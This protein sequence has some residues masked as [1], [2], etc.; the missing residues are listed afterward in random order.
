M[1]LKQLFGTT[2]LS[3][4]AKLAILASTVILARSLGAEEYGKYVYW[5]SILN[6]LVALSTSGVPSLLNK[7]VPIYKDNNLTEHISGLHFSLNFTLIAIT[8]SIFLCISFGTTEKFNL[9]LFISSLVLIRGNLIINT[10]YA[11]SIKFHNFL[12]TYKHLLPSLLI[13]VIF[14]T[15]ILN[16]KINFE[17]DFEFAIVV[18]LV[19]TLF[20]A[21]LC[22]AHLKSVDVAH[23]HRPLAFDIKAWAPL[24]LSLT[25]IS[26]VATAGNEI[27]SV[28]IAKITSFEQVAI[29][30]IASQG[31]FL[32]M[33]ANT[34]INQYMMPLM[35][36][37]YSQ[38]RLHDAQDELAKG[39]ILSTLCSI[40]ALITI[41]VAGHSIIN[42]LFG[43]AYSKTITPLLILLGFQ[44]AANLM[45]SSIAL[46][47]M[48]GMQRTALKLSTLISVLYIAST[49]VLTYTNG[50]I[51]SAIALGSSFLLHRII[52]SYLVYK[53]INIHTGVTFRR[54]Y[55]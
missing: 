27:S 43:A 51:G 36:L 20:T 52:A 23:K 31:F 13:F 44:V 33:I 9:A 26:F 3:L 12:P 48:V 46:L 47:S 8:L 42:I 22:G 19:A 40:S 45:G 10:S 7:V 25:G 28:I 4:L 21:L 14:Y 29:W 2:F 17:I 53:E 38:R 49:V 39:A 15:I 34:V 30:K 41:S 6:L 11:N 1:I 37:K 50:I 32:S 24:F 16:S 55:S 18:T 35:S 5:I 54:Y